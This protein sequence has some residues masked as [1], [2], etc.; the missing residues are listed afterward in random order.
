MKD[1]RAAGLLL[2]ESKPLKGLQLLQKGGVVGATAVDAAAWLRGNMHALSRDAVG[3]LFGMGDAFAV[4]VMHAYIDLVRSIKMSASCIHK[5]RID[6]C[7]SIS[8]T[9]TQHS[10]WTSSYH[11]MEAQALRVLVM[12][13]L[14]LHSFV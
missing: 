11:S 7:S 12:H 3:E 8:H 4:A 14:S 5:G 2:F 13:L 9:A 6:L 10:T 1:K